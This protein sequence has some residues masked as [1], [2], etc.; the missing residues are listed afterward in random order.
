[1]DIERFVILNNMKIHCRRRRL[2]VILFVGQFKFFNHQSEQHTH[3]PLYYI[4]R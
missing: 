2:L 4:M 3:G 1:M